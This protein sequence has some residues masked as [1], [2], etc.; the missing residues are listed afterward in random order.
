MVDEWGRGLK[1]DFEVVGFF[2][3]FFLSVYCG[4]EFV[5]FMSYCF[6]DRCMWFLRFWG[7]RGIV[8]RCF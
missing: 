4:V 6:L 2:M 8:R 7:L 1:K 3:E 5:F